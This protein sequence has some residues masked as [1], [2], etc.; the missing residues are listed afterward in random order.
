MPCKLNAKLL[1]ENLEVIDNVKVRFEPKTQSVSFFDEELANSMFKIESTNIVFMNKNSNV[2]ISSYIYINKL[3]YK[4][5]KLNIYD[6]YLECLVYQCNNIPV[7]INDVF[8]NNNILPKNQHLNINNDMDTPSTFSSIKR[9]RRNNEIIPIP[10]KVK[11]RGDYLD[12][13]IW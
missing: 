13:W 7:N 5:I 1:N 8:D 10:Y 12:V 9:K 4:I 11:H 3:L 2:D 6:T